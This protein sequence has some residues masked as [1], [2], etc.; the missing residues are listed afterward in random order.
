MLPLSLPHIKGPFCE[1]CG[2]KT[3]CQGFAPD[4]VPPNPKL[5]FLAEA[6]GENEM[7]E[8]NPLVGATGRMFFH[9]LLHPCG[10]IRDDV[11]LANV[12][13]GRP[14]EN[15]YPT[16]KDRKEAEK[17]CRQYDGF[18]RNQVGPDHVEL[19]EGGLD[20]FSPD[21]YMITCHPA[22]VSRT[23][24]ILRVVQQDIQK[25]LRLSV[26]KRLIVCLGDKAMSLVAPEL[27]G[28]VL[29]WRAHHGPLDWKSVKR[30]FE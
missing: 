27:E 13:R 16:G 19:I 3:V 22:F 25:A 17:W 8:R 1:P 18:Q 4:H 11:I 29:K 2:Y 23:W 5:A 28:G 6:L 24:S 26:G 20:A 15:N 14:P 21:Y 9:N 30:R 7:M 10:L 12:I